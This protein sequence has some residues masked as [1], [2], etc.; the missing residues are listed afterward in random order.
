VPVRTAVFG[1][2]TD[3]WRTGGG[4]SVGRVT[5]GFA[6]DGHGR[7]VPGRFPADAGADSSVHAGLPGRG[8]AILVS[9]AEDYYSAGTREITGAFPGAS[10]EQLGPD[11]AAVTLNGS[12]L[13]DLAQAIRNAPLVFARHLSAEAW[14]FS[15]AEARMDSLSARHVPWLTTISRLANP[16]PCN[17]G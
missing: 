3:V 13:D 7:G 15:L 8:G 17:A 2:S 5:A 1:G 14:R 12:S 4:R 9:F 11:L 16:S 10:V 6:T